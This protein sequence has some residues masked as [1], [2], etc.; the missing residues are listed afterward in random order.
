MIHNE[1]LWSFFLVYLMSLKQSST[2]SDSFPFCNL[3]WNPLEGGLK[4][5]RVVGWNFFGGT[6]FKWLLMFVRFITFPYLFS[7]NFPNYSSANGTLLSIL[8]KG[9]AP[10][11]SCP[12]KKVKGQPALRFYGSSLLLLTRYW[13]LNTKRCCRIP[14]LMDQF[15][16]SGNWP[17]RF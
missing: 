8:G 2:I 9:S 12:N 11:W 13:P 4:S 1:S 17:R 10:Q 16:V 7:T 3:L 14:F 5:W 6:I 15:S